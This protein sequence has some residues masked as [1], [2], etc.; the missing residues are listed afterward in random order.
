MSKISFITTCKGR[1]DH[2]KVTLPLLVKQAIAEEVIFVDYGCPEGSGKWVEENFPRVKVVYVNNDPGFCAAR[3]RNYGAAVAKSK[4]LCFIDADIIIGIG[5]ISWLKKH[6]SPTK[7]YRASL[8]NGERD[9]ETWGTCLCERFAFEALGGYDEAYRGWG[10]EDDDLYYRLKMSDYIESE[11]PFSFVTAINHHDEKRMFHYQIK[12][13]S[14]HWFINETYRDV[15]LSIMRIQGANTQL[16]LDNRLNL[17]NQI[18]DKILAWKSNVNNQ[19]PV[20]KISIT[21]VSWLPDDFYLSGNYSVEF[22]I[23]PKVIKSLSS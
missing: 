2:V 10:G 5:F 22:S 6:L 13:K 23:K 16:T 8:I 14:T 21:N 3:A 17:M 20:F 19:P 12:E 7:F 4:W 11:Y 15:K 18:K 9:K 1:L